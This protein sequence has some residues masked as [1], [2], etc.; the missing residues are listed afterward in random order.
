MIDLP[1]F[2]QSTVVSTR[3]RLARNLADYPFPEKLTDGEAQKIIRAVRYELDQMDFFDEYD[4]AC[5]P[6]AQATLLQEK[7]LIS[8]ALI[9]KKSVGAAFISADKSISVMVN[10][11]D[12]LRE[13]YILQG[14]DLYKAYERISMVDDFLGKNMNFA[15]DHRLGYLTACPSNLGTGMRASVMLF[16]PGLSRYG[17]LEEL[18]PKLKEKGMT[19]RGVF[20]EGSAAEGYMYQLSNERTLG[21][22]E[23]E[24]LSAVERTAAFLGG[25]EADARQ[26][27][28]TED[29]LHL[30]D[31]CFRA[32]GT[33]TNC[34]VL[35]NEELS[36]LL[37][38]IRLGIA[39]G[40]L[41]TVDKKAF[42]NFEWSMQP[43]S[44]H[45]TYCDGE[46]S[47]TD[48]DVKRAEVVS[49]GLSKLLDRIEI[50]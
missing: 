21:I 28:L 35:S 43:T 13:Q 39:L 6:A 22:T 12:H 42:D 15:Y 34:A 45:L 47:K 31:V 26:K 9:K 11:E 16:L 40:F 32:Y 49:K 50:M 10:E 24:I 2:T 37:V 36:S 25:E 17:R 33:L 14:F 30:M 23:R 7:H 8:P 20:G 46:M 18:M 29:G 44:F 38:K 4:L 3:I 27:M 1:S 48:C 5:M 19:V 41:K